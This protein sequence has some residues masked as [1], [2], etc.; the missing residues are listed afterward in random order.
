MAWLERPIKGVL[1]D[2]SGVL[3][4]GGLAIPG[5]LEAF[6]KLKASG[7]PVR[8]VTNESQV[9]RAESLNKLVK[10][11]YEDIELDY[12]TAPA[13]LLVER[14]RRE[15]LVPHLLV[16]PNVVPEFGDLATQTDSPNCVVIADAAS[17][18][19]YDTLNDAFRVL[20]DMQLKGASPKLFTL[21]RGRYYKEDGQLWMDVG[22][23]CRAL[24]YAVDIEA[25]LVGKPAAS[26]FHG[27][28]D[29]IGVQSQDA[30]MVGDDII[31]DVKGAKDAGIRG[32]L[33]R[34]GKYR[35]VDENQ[36]GHH[37]DAIVDNLAEA[38]ELI[39]SASKRNP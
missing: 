36:H 16:H 11:G 13:P 24:E 30:V 27:A 32:V 28:L 19:T 6:H 18:F 7:I 31:G 15:G 26:F 4:D 20:L 14:L 39:L 2:I 25:E 10:L 29:S 12:I 8:L 35:T 23:F 3:R 5:S 1:L 38:V 37:A 9:T 21:G 34:T 17:H 22:P 33:V